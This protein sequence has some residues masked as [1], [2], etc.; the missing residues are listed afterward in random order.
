MEGGREERR[1]EE[2]KKDR[3]GREE[4]GRRAPSRR[5]EAREPR[6][7]W[8]EAEEAMASAREL[9]DRSMWKSR[10]WGKGERRLRVRMAMDWR[11]GEEEK[12]EPERMRRK[13][14]ESP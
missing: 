1:G 14:R 12:E 11:D 10:T 6:Q 8:R 4:G 13:E 7:G 2:E 5:E 3:G 9:S